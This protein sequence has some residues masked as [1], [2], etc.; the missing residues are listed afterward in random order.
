[1]VK[2]IDKIL[3]KAFCY[4]QSLCRYIKVHLVLHRYVNQMERK[5][6]KIIYLL[7][8]KRFFLEST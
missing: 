8:Y 1:M 6:D 5:Y 2:N 4:N 7:S 3:T